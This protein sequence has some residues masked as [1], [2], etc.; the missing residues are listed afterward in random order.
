MCY[1]VNVNIQQWFTHTLAETDW[2]MRTN[3][4]TLCGF[5]CAHARHLRAT[6]T[7]YV[8]RNLYPVVYGTLSGSTAHDNSVGSQEFWTSRAR[9]AHSERSFGWWAWPSTLL[10]RGR[11]LHAQLQ[12]EEEDTKSRSAGENRRWRYC[13]F[14]FS[15][16]SLYREPI[17]SPC[18][19]S[20][21]DHCPAAVNILVYGVHEY[22]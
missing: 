2:R 12:W 21:L 18:E 8:N 16:F 3:P 22:P 7:F 15:S 14:L 5:S 10:D 4:T 19:V 1:A 17:L 6:F 9:N 13:I 11:A 20:L